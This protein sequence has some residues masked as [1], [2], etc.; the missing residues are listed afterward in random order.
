MEYRISDKK[1]EIV[2]YLNGDMIKSISS[3]QL[4]EYAETC[5]K[6][7]KNGTE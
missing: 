4:A 1:R 2:L 3:D 7:I 6:G 5:F